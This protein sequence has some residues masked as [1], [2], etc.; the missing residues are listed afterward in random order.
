MGRAWL[1]LVL[2]GGLVA[3]T[4]ASFPF[5]S[6]TGYT[7]FAIPFGA[8]AAP[9]DPIPYDEL[10][11]DSQ[12]I[13]EA[14]IE[15]EGELT[16]YGSWGADD[17]EAAGLPAI[18]ADYRI[19]DTQYGAYVLYDDTVYEI[20]SPEQGQPGYLWLVVGG[21]VVAGVLLVGAGIEARRREWRNDIVLGVAVAGLLAVFWIA[22]YGNALGHLWGVR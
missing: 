6:L 4:A 22:S 21:G 13:V 3:I 8:E 20:G 10:D 19:G 11:A 18:V 7:V 2:V 9:D 1:A 5:W 14:A 16:V 15:R 12:A 17:R